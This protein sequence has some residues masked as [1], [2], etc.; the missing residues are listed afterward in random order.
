MDVAFFLSFLSFLSFKKY[1]HQL[2]LEILLNISK[3]ISHLSHKKDMKFITRKSLISYFYEKK[4]N[5]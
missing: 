4:Y 2:L 5:F 3:I 1:F